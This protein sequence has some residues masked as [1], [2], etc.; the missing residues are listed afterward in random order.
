[1]AE[2]PSGVK[3]MLYGST[4]GIAG[5]GWPVFGSIGTRS[6]LSLSVMYSVWRSHDGTQCCGRCPTSK[7]STISIESW[8]MTST[9]FV[10]LFGT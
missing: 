7:W 1:M 9:V 2:V 6:W 10:S 4:T 8:S 3:Y 5:P